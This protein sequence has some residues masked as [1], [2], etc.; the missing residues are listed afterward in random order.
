MF[1]L[2]EGPSEVTLVLFSWKGGYHDTTARFQVRGERTERA[3]GELQ[4]GTISS[5]RTDHA[6]TSGS[7]KVLVELDPGG[8][9]VGL[10]MIGGPLE[11]APILFLLDLR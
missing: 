6:K 8:T 3:L 4:R 1:A 2:P 10:R 5:R 11:A 9:T 7:N